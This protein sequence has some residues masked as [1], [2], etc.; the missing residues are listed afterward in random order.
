MNEIEL[1]AHKIS[2]VMLM[3]KNNHS[4]HK[5]IFIGDLRIEDRYDKLSFMF[6]DESN[7]KVCFAAFAQ[8]NPEQASPVIYEN[9][10]GYLWVN[11]NDYFFYDLKQNDEIEKRT[12]KLNQYKKTVVTNNGSKLRDISIFERIYCL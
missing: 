12:I 9:S 10:E 1:L 8:G 7:A 11:T 5:Y 6:K 4:M 2:T 3:L